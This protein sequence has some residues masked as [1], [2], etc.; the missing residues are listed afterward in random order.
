MVGASILSFKPLK[1]LGIDFISK[2]VGQQYLDN[3]GDQNRALDPYLVH[4]L[5]LNYSI[6]PGK[7]AKQLVFGLLINNIGNLMYSAN[8]YTYP[9]VFNGNFMADN[10]LY[11]QAGTNFLANV[12]LRF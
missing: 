6:V 3:S 7:M 4:D 10:T 5:R 12:Q 1:G 9:Y 11:P 2:Y 8:G